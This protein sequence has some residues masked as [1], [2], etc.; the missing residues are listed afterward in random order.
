MRNLKEEPTG[1]LQYLYLG[2][3][4]FYK[5]KYVSRYYELF[6]D[7][8]NYD[9]IKVMIQLIHRS[10][11]VDEYVDYILEKENYVEDQRKGNTTYVVSRDEVYAALTAV[12]NAEGIEKVLRHELI[13]NIRRI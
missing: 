11:L 3:E 9:A 1:D 4:F 12:E 5:E 10:D 6:K 7:S 13:E 8:T 2:N